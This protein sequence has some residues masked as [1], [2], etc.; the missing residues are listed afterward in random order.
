MLITMMLNAPVTHDHWNFPIQVYYCIWY[1]SSM[2]H[3][4]QYQYCHIVNMHCVY[5]V[6]V[7]VYFETWVKP[8]SRILSTFL[9]L[10]QCNVEKGIFSFTNRPQ[11]FGMCRSKYHPE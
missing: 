9:L 2:H 1:E 11:I 8:C 5:S 6:C 3:A 10:K 4:Y 7:V